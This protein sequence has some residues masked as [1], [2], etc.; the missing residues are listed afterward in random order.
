MRRDDQ[1]LNKYRNLLTALILVALIAG[2]QSS[3]AAEQATSG[4][5]SSTIPCFGFTG[6]IPTRVEAG[7]EIRYVVPGDGPTTLT[8]LDIEGHAVVRL[9]EGAELVGAQTVR[10]SGRD[11]AGKPLANGVYFIRLQAGGYIDIR[12]VIVIQ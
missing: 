5:L 4:G 10:W 7:A 6:N 3:S 1:P 11:K 12:K 9:V 2:A 8:V